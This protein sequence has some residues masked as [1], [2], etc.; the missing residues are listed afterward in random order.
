VLSDVAQNP[1]ECSAQ[2]SGASTAEVQRLRQRLL[3]AEESQGTLQQRLA[4]TDACLC[5]LRADLD[6]ERTALAK[7]L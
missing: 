1:A 2:A 3:E 4:G 7:V 6:A 5:A